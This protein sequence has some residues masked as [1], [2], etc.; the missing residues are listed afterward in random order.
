VELLRGVVEQWPGNRKFW[1]LAL[2]FRGG[3]R[4]RSP[5]SDR[6]LPSRTDLLNRRRAP[7]FFVA[8]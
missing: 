6:R 3:G 5:S 2:V 8:N 4:R 1:P 7:F